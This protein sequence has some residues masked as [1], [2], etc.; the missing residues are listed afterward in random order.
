MANS[1]IR[2]NERNVIRIA[3][4]VVATLLCIS[5]TSDREAK[6]LFLRVE[7][8]MEEYPDSALALI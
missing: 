7:A 6:D 1:K 3:L 8:V 5:C 4:I 2:M